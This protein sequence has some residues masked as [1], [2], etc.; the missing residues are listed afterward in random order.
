MPNLVPIH[1]LDDFTGNPGTDMPAAGGFPLSF[2]NYLV[3][4]IM[5]SGL[6]IGGVANSSSF[7]TVTGGISYATSSGSTAGGVDYATSSGTAKGR[8]D[9]QISSSIGGTGTYASPGLSVSGGSTSGSSVDTTVAHGGIG[10]TE[11]PDPATQMRTAPTQKAT[12]VATP[13]ASERRRTAT[14][15]ALQEWEG[16]VISVSRSSFIAS[17]VDLTN[18]GTRPS[19]EAEIP[20]DELSENDAAKLKPG[21]IFRWAIGYQR[22]PSGTKM[23]VSQIV[24][25]ELPQ[26]TRR[27]LRDAKERAAKLKDFLDKPDDDFHANGTSIR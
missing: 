9:Y 25:R 3:Q 27:E 12:G 2:G 7:G 24:F 1:Q 20:I 10:L 19:E 8:I 6:N 14:F 17:L 16:Y 21:Q 4:P 23:R 13:S 22:S 15:A 11:N 5:P 26:W 18:G